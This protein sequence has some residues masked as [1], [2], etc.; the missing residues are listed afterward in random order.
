MELTSRSRRRRKGATA[1]RREAVAR[2]EAYVRAHIATPV[3]VS[4]LSRIVGLSE[5]GLRNAF[6]SVRGMSP[7]RCVLAERLE[8]VRRALADE[9]TRPGT[10]TD[11]ATAYGFCEL[12]R[13]AGSYRKAFG[14]APSDTLRGNVARG[15]TA[16]D[17]ANTTRPCS[18]LDEP[19]KRR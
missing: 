10:V 5:R 12:G 6:Y 7:K 17:R 4:R 9:S 18:C 1:S 11:I 15:E 2:A 19:A 14:E 16:I 13:F 3:P 8:R